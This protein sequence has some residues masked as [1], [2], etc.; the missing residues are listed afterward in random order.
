MN[1]Q[2]ADHLDNSNCTVN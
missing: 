1:E 2:I